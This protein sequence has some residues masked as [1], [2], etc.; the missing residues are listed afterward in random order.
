VKNKK[1]KYVLRIKK[2]EIDIVSDVKDSVYV[3]FKKPF[4]INQPPIRFVT[5][6]LVRK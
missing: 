4:E 2:S 5:N 3:F 1:D 6:A